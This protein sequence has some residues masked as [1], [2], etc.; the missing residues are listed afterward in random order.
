MDYSDKNIGFRQG[1][2]FVMDRLDGSAKNQDLTTLVTAQAAGDMKNDGSGGS[3]PARTHINRSMIAID[4]LKVVTAYEDNR[5]IKQ[6]MQ[7]PNSANFDAMTKDRHYAEAHYSSTVATP[8]VFKDRACFNSWDEMRN[9]FNEHND[10]LQAVVA[11]I[12]VSKN[13]ALIDAIRAT[14]VKRTTRDDDAEPSY[15]DVALPES[16]IYTL[17]SNAKTLTYKDLLMIRARCQR[18]NTKQ[19]YMLMSWAQQAEF[20]ATNVQDLQNKDFVASSDLR[21]LDQSITFQGITPVIVEDEYNVQDNKVFGL[22]ESEILIFNPTAITKVH[23]TDES[24]YGVD[25]QA[26]GQAHFLRKIRA[27]FVRTSDKGVMIV[28]IPALAP[29]LNLGKTTV[30]LVKAGTAQEISVTTNANRVMQQDWWVTSDADWITITDGSGVG[31]GT[32]AIGATANSTS[33]SRS[34]L[35]KVRSGDLEQTITVT[36]AGS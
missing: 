18:M 15:A 17:G 1:V 26:D 25:M 16:Q 27:D 23:W 2:K 34:A 32:F 14:S 3:L 11:N 7:N 28:K 12:R 29:Q 13:K 22:D 21:A 31:S 5:L 35:V 33:S 36:Q 8:K 24:I 19:T 9:G 10:K 30:S 4:E 20:K 6:Y